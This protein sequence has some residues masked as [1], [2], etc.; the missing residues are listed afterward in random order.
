MKSA[1]LSLTIF[2]ALALAACTNAPTTQQSETQPGETKPSGGI[3]E[4]AK[5]AAPPV[6]L[7]SGTAIAVR[8]D[9]ALSTASNKAGDTFAASLDEPVM[10]GGK[11]VLPKGTKFTGH[12]TT[13]DASGRLQGRGVLGI[14]L[15]SFDF[16]GQ[17]YPVASSLDTKTTDSHKKRNIEMIGGG[18]GLGALIGGLTGGGKGAAIGA[19]AGAAAGTGVAA[20]TGKKEVEV[21]AETVFRFTLKNP[22]KVQTE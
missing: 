2:L 16:K 21:P 10:E 9:Q 12:V 22:V 5:P 4:M 18:A 20:A 15:D 14:T 3:S 17:N 8:L 11:E 13:S 1:I 7:P 6:E 19:G